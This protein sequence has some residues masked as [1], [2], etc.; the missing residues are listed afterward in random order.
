MTLQIFGTKKCKDTKKAQRFFKERS[1]DFQFIDLQQKEM[2]QGEF[3]SVVRAIGGM[4]ELIDWDSKDK[5]GLAHLKYR[6]EEQ[7]EEILRESPQLMK[8][9]ILRDGSKAV[10]GHQEKVWKEWAEEIKKGK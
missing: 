4:E 3:Q 9:P 2:S 7:K 8:T 5:D 10:V 1:I 6:V